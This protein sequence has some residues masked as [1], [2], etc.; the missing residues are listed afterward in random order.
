[1]SNVQ[2]VQEFYNIFSHDPL[3]IVK[4]ERRTRVSYHYF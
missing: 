4:Y 1:M 2:D 3:L